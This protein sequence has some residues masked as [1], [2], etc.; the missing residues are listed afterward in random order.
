MFA[1]AQSATVF[2]L[3]PL[4][5]PQ[6]LVPPPPQNCGAV[7]VPQSMMPPQPS[8]TGPHEPVG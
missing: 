1:V 2:G 3:Q 4:S 5:P 8:A 6:T 7:Q